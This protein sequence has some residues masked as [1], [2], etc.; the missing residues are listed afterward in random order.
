[1]L[2]LSHFQIASKMPWFSRS[3]DSKKGQKPTTGLY[4]GNQPRRPWPRAE[5]DGRSKNSRHSLDLVSDAGSGSGKGSRSPSPSSPNN[6]SSSKGR[7]SR[8]Q[9][10]PLPCAPLVKP[11]ERTYSAGQLPNSQNHSVSTLPHAPSMPLPSPLTRM[12]ST[13]EVDY[14]SGS[15]SSVSSLGSV[16]VVDPRQQARVSNLRPTQEPEAPEQLRPVSQ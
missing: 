4:D 15:V 6:N 16:E 10:L 3:K 12:E 2:L 11:M 1:L 9:P 7:H 13:T 5:D 8:G 14:P